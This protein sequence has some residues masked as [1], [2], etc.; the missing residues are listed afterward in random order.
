MI[1][2][3]TFD[4]DHVQLFNTDI[5]DR[6]KDTIVFYIISELF[7]NTFVLKGIL[8]HSRTYSPEGKKSDGGAAAKI[9]PLILLKSC[10]SL[11]Y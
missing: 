6:K 4:F 2:V 3:L 11:V 9:T 5:K 1:I 10:R 8:K 7:L